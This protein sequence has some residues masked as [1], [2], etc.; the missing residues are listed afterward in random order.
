MDR[1]LSKEVT[2]EIR[3]CL[4]K[5]ESLIAQWL[6]FDFT[7]QKEYEPHSFPVS[8]SLTDHVKASRQRYQYLADNVK[9]KINTE[10]NER[11]TNIVSEMQDINLKMCSL[12]KAIKEIQ[13]WSKKLS[14]KFRGGAK[15]YQRTSEVV[16]KSIKKLQRWCKKAIKQLQ[17]WW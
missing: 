3:C 14:K 7:K 15:S 5:I 17:R 9:L 2:T 11:E 6:I 8:K 10:K 12:E 16:Q 1:L 4:L 13:R